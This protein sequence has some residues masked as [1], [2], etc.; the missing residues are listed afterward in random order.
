[1]TSHFTM[2]YILSSGKYAVVQFVEEDSVEVIPSSW[3]I[4]DT[5]C[6]WPSNVKSLAMKG[7]VTN[8]KP[9]TG[10]FERHKCEVIYASGE[11]VKI[12]SPC[13]LIEARNAM[14]YLCVFIVYDIVMKAVQYQLFFRIN[15]VSCNE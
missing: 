2:F 11:I 7:M 12:L 15:V 1:M 3:M 5:A 14:S 13:C 6:K 8:C 4:G 9:I 10:K